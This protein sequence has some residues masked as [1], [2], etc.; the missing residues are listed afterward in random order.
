MT[1][2]HI[3]MP[4][5]HP[6]DVA[7]GHTQETGVLE[8]TRRAF[9][10]IHLNVGYFFRILLGGTVSNVSTIFQAIFSGST[11]DLRPYLW[12]YIGHFRPYFL[13][14]SRKNRPIHMVGTSNLFAS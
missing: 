8:V 1:S 11:G 10:I 12:E 4:S 7:V 14:Y 6:S 13:R 9:G 5:V 3:H 2:Y